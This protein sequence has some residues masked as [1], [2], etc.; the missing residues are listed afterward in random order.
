MNIVFLL[1][2]ELDACY[3]GEWRMF[4]F[5]QHFPERTQSLFFIYAH[6]FI[7]A[8]VFYYIWHVFNFTAKPLWIMVNVFA[9]FHWVIHWIA[10]RWKSN[11]FHK[12]SSFFFMGGYALS[13]LINLILYPLY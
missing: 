10:L 1:M 12:P 4:K 5:L 3:E 13:G 7:Y 11:V 9:V 6:F 2:H 8:F